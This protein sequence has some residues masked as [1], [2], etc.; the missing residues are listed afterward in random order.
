MGKPHFIFTVFKSI[1]ERESKVIFNALA[2]PVI[3]VQE[4]IV[5]DI[6]CKVGCVGAVA[7]NV[8]LEIVDIFAISEPTILLAPERPIVQIARGVLLLLVFLLAENYGLHASFVKT[9][10]LC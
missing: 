5:V 10:G 7:G 8:I 9:V 2:M 4:F 3:V 6:G 1:L